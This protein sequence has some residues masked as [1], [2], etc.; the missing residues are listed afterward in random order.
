MSWSAEWK[1][2]NGGGASVL[3]GETGDVNGEY[4]SSTKLPLLLLFPIAGVD[5]PFTCRLV[6]LLVPLVILLDVIT[7]GFTSLGGPGPPPLGLSPTQPSI[8]WL[9]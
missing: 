2:S 3:G 1:S 5:L 9:V 4:G 6:V 8:G 7:H